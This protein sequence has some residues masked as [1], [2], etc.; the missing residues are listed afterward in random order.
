MDG[1]GNAPQPSYTQL[2]AWGWVQ[3]EQPVDF[4]DAY[5]GYRPTEVGR[6][7]FLYDEQYHLL[8]IRK[9]QIATVEARITDSLNIAT[10]AAMASVSF[11]GQLARAR[12]WVPAPLVYELA[13]NEAA[14]ARYERRGFISLDRFQTMYKYSFDELIV[15]GILRYLEHRD[16]EKMANIVVGDKAR[17]CLICSSRWQVFLVRPGMADDLAALCRVNEHFIP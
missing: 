12:G 14:L 2:V 5:V 1:G 7:Y 17:H 16:P 4:L 15:C 6:K 8:F 10:E 13:A 9:E 11:Q 3:R